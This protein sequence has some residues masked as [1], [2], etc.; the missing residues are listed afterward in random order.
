MPG[1]Q[2]CKKPG[3]VAARVD[4]DGNITSLNQTVVWWCIVDPGREWYALEL[5]PPQ[6]KSKMINAYL[7]LRIRH[8]VQA[9]PMRRRLAA[10]VA[11]VSDEPLSVEGAIDCLPACLPACQVVFCD[12]R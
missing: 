9:K 6:I 12:A 3:C 8:A 2:G 11:A 10:G 1:E 7:D 4:L 5:G